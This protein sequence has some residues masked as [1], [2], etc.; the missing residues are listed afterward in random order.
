MSGEVMS[1]CFKQSSCRVGAPHA[2]KVNA[3]VTSS[4]KNE[5]AKSPFL[6][7]VRGI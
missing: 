2:A 4:I 7:V 6:R 3:Q 5:G 1:R